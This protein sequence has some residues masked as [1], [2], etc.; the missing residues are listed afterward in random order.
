[1]LVAVQINSYC[2]GDPEQ[3]LSELWVVVSFG[4]PLNEEIVEVIVLSN[5][6][7]QPLVHKSA[8]TPSCPEPGSNSL[9]E[10]SQS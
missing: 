8:F 5:K 9:Q 3:V 2:I 6:P 7:H 10:A 1:M 4:L